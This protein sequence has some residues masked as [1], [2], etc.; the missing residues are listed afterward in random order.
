MPFHRELD[1]Q[2]NSKRFETSNP[3]SETKIERRCSD[4]TGIT[5]KTNETECY[6]TEILTG[7]VPFSCCLT[8]N[9]SFFQQGSIKNI[10]GSQKMVWEVTS[11]TRMALELVEGL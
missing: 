1:Y 5:I 11:I 7:N 2:F 6:R 8:G 10:R 3:S 4:T 9:V